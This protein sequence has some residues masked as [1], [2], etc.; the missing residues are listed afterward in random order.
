MLNLVSPESTS[1]TE[2]KHVNP[3]FTVRTYAKKTS[4]ARAS[5]S[6]KFLIEFGITG[7]HI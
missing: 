5:P 6:P 4:R 7:K 1:N 2:N 3:I